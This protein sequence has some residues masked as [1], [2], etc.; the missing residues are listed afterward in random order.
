M[1]E[2]LEIVEELKTIETSRN[3]IIER[4]LRENEEIVVEY[5]SENQLFEKG[6]DGQGRSLGNYTFATMQIKQRK[7]QPTDRMTLRDTGEFHRRFY[8]EFSPNGFSIRSSDD[9]EEMLKDEHGESIMD[10]NDE[11]LTDLMENY[12]M[13]ELMK[14]L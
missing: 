13:P 8:I 9:K 11:N 7:N 3:E 14:M 12:V 6:E 2:L 5:V 4:V 1:Q 10:I